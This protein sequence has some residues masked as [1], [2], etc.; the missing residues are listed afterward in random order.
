MVSWGRAKLMEIFSCRALKEEPYSQK[1]AEAAVGLFT[2]RGSASTASPT[3]RSAR[4]DGLTP[5]DTDMVPTNSNISGSTF[6]AATTI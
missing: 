5:M 3:A 1:E 6:N 4:D 2:V